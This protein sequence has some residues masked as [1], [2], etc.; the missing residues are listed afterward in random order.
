MLRSRTDTP[1]R[2][3]L[4]DPGVA[5]TMPRGGRGSQ[6]VA[7]VAAK[8]AGDEGASGRHHRDS[9][10]FGAASSV[11]RVI[12]FFSFTEV[13]DPGAHRAYNEWHQFDHL[14]EQFSID[15]IVFGQRWVYTPACRATG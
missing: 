8:V 6:V 1:E 5:L 10:S 2:N 12:G 3:A 4:D 7:K 9:C 11:Q 15:G 14:P 13:T